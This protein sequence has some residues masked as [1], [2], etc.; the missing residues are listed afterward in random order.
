MEEEAA[1]DDD[2]PVS[3]GEVEAAEEAAEGVAA[4]VL[5]HETRV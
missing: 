2:V 5:N 4:V 1:D 3:V